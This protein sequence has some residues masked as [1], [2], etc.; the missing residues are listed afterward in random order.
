MTELQIYSFFMF[1]AGVILTRIIFHIEKSWSKKQIY[2]NL[3]LS[4]IRFLWVV[5]YLDYTREYKSEKV[6]NVSQMLNLNNQD[7]EKFTSLLI[8]SLDED[9][10]KRVRFNSWA[11]VKNILL[12]GIKNERS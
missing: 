4:L 8:S 7:M 1:W 12:K 11:D 9:G 2:D 6:E 3:S 5:C 10:R